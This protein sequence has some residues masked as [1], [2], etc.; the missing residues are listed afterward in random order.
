MREFVAKTLL[1]ELQFDMLCE[2][3]SLLL[4]E[5]LGD[6][7]S[8]FIRGGLPQACRISIARMIK[9]CYKAVVI[10]LDCADA[11]AQARCLWLREQARLNV[12]CSKCA[13]SLPSLWGSIRWPHSTHEK[14]LANVGSRLVRA[15]A[16]W[17]LM[18]HSLA[19]TI[20]LP[21]QADEPKSISGVPGGIWPGRA[22]GRPVGRPGPFGYR[23][24]R[25]PEVSQIS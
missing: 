7:R 13:G 21:P 4:F 12:T 1:T 10:S 6:F 9:E 20:S 23:A 5:V 16:N 22:P 18:E 14:C 8:V 3:V 17:T 2:P 24:I 19:L 25:W 15:S 11:R